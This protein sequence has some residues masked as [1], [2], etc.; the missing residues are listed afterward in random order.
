MRIASSFLS[1]IKLIWGNLHVVGALFGYGLF[2]CVIGVVTG[3]F[4]VVV[5]VIGSVIG[6]VLMVPVF[7]IELILRL[8][9]GKF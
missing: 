6:F 3:A 2:G 4:E 8:I 7:I 5:D 9:F 1:S